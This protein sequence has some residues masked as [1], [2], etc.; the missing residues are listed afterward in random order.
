MAAAVD[1]ESP[2][3]SPRD[4]ERMD[5][6]ESEGNLFSPVNDVEVDAAPLTSKVGNYGNHKHLQ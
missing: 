1:I 5:T 6:I 3:L 4:V 2:T